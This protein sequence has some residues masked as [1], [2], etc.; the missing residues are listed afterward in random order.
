MKVE[1]NTT[2]L[3]QRNGLFLPKQDSDHKTTSYFN[4]KS[5]FEIWQEF[6]NGSEV[7][8][9]NI[10]KHFYRTLYNYASQFTLDRNLINDVI[11]DLFIELINKRERLS[12][13]TSIKF[14]LFRSV[15]N[16]LVRKLKKNSKMNCID[17]IQGCYDFAISFSTERLLINQQIKDEQKQKLNLAVKKLNSRQREIIYYYYFEN[18]NFKEISEIMD[19]TNHKSVQNLLYRSINKLKG[20]LFLS[21]TIFLVGT[22][23]I[24]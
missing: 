2:N 1:K 19:F 10:Y 6:K 14:Y 13:T 16:L 4:L 21:F 12:D 20:I 7:A 8:L 3:N 11:Q 15:K 23:K 5:E 17:N 18:L 24:G 22:I 9:I